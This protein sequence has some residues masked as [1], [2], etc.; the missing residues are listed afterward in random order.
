MSIGAGFGHLPDYADLPRG[1]SG[2]GTAWG[3]FGPDDGLGL[4]NLQT[5]ERVARAMR[6]APRGQVFAL[7]AAVDLFDP[8]FFARRTAPRHTVFQRNARSSD[9]VWDNFFPQGSSQWDGLGHVGAAND[10]FYG[11]AT[12]EEVRTGRRN[13]IDAWGARGIVGRGVLVD[14]AD[15]V[16]DSSVA[17][18][19]AGDRPPVG[20][21][22]PITV[23]DLERAR[24]RA[25][26]VFEPGDVMLVH[27]GF[28]SWYESLPPEGRAAFV[29]G[30][31]RN[32]GLAHGEEM[33]AYLWD[34]HISAVAIDNVAV[35]VWPPD[36]S[37]AGYPFG[38]LHHVLIGEFGMALG[39]LWR[40]GD[41]AASCRDDGVYE[42][43]VVSAPMRSPG[44]TGSPAN[45]VAVK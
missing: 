25:G 12:A 6:L 1:V 34:Q 8:P 18:A 22:V 4:M 15:A 27:T 38:F 11:G 3:L 2:A 37:A 31:V 43:A 36:Q 20:E 29:A 32:A 14:V 30:G 39:E 42:C 5:P 17:T 24:E 23:A 40:L 9:D 44:G 19:A 7:S 41:L 10:A 13:S 26:L 35:E 45:A 28:V 33:V 16:A 21:S